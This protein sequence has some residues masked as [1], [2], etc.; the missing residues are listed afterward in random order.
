MSIS[1]KELCGILIEIVLTLQL[2]F[3]RLRPNNSILQ[4]KIFM[5]HI[6]VCMYF[7]YVHI[8]GIK[9]QAV[10]I[11]ELKLLSHGYK[12]KKNKVAQQVLKQENRKMTLFRRLYIYINNI[13]FISHF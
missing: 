5:P 12:I 1:S 4:F 11:Q 7:I 2:E 6:Y 10:L 13:Q 9:L 3:G 8:Y